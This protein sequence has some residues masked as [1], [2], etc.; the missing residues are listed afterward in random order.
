LLKTPTK[1]QESDYGAFH[2]HTETK[3]LP[4]SK[5]STLSKTNFKQNKMSK[6]DSLKIQEMIKSEPEF[7]EKKI[8]TYGQ[9]T[10]MQYPSKSK[11]SYKNVE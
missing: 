9:S 11:M 4:R 8:N 3:A 1:N 10:S 7:K 6:L 5:Y 2:N